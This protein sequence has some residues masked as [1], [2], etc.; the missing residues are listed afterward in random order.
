MKNSYPWRESFLSAMITLL[1]LLAGAG[2]A[3]SEV[4]PAPTE[5]RPIVDLSVSPMTKY[6]WRGQEMSKDS[7]VIQPSMT[8]GY[9][10]FTANLWGNLDTKPYTP[11]GQSY[12]GTLT[13][14]DLTF[15]YS[16]AFGSVT[17][18]LGY[19]Y[20]GLA[21]AH[22]GVTDP[23]DSQEVFLTVTVNKLLSP[24]L[25]VY[26]E[27]DHYHQW[28][29]LLGISH[30]VELGKAVSL[31]L[32]ASAGYLL[33]DDAGMYPKYDSHALA[34][35]EKYNNFHEAVIT[36]SL[37]VSVAKYMTVTPVVSY[38]F[39]LCDDAKYD[40]QAR[41]QKVAWGGAMPSDGD[42]SYLYG[43]ITLSFTY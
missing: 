41:S 21:A 4:T 13:E 38:V 17:A 35:A 26:K 14:T 5:E 7:I 30:A 31:K 10:G 8:V 37:P 39:P 19:I 34:T 40:M 36:A 32:T 12:A 18:G 1:V 29:F 15:S 43:G 3:L 9:K 20:Y 42:S 6:V 24:S 28:Y 22:T 25:T 23:P 27:I 11:T 2:P 33:S 16:R